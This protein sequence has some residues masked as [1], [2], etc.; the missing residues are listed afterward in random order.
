[1]AD[2]LDSGS[3]GR[4][5]VW[6]QVPSLAPINQMVSKFNIFETIFLPIFLSRIGT[7]IYLKYK[8]KKWLKIFIVLLYYS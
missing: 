1:M 3:S 5:V 8:F 6:V 7:L 4:K 2:A